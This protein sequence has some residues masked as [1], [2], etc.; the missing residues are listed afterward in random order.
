MDQQLK[1]RWSQDIVGGVNLWSLDNR[2]WRDPEWLDITHHPDKIKQHVSSVPKGSWAPNEC[3]KKIVVWMIHCWYIPL[4]E[5][6]LTEQISKRELVDDSTVGVIQCVY[7]RFY[8]DRISRGKKCVLYFICLQFP[9]FMIWEPPLSREYLGEVP[10][11]LHIVGY[12][13]AI[14]CHKAWQTR[15]IVFLRWW[16]I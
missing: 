4:P 16:F 9:Q 7:Y 2:F 10:H 12:N 3:P 5:G 14:Y 15:S 13:I 8:M 6:R 11:G 1:P